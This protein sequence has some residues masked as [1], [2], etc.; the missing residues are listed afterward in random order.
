[1]TIGSVLILKDTLLVPRNALALKWSNVV[2][3]DS[4][5]AIRPRPAS[6]RWEV[7]LRRR[8]VRADT[9]LNR[10]AIDLR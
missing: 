8:V 4:W 5:N 3:T 9:G 6:G 10:S 2:S 7:S 1:M